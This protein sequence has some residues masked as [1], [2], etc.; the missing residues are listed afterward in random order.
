[1]N[2]IVLNESDYEMFDACYYNM[3]EFY[4]RDREGDIY[5][6]SE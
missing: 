1:M 2:N 3:D 5:N 4:N 6:F